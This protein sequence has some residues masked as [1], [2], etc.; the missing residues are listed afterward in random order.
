MPL[1]VLPISFGTVAGGRASV[2]GLLER[3]GGDIAA[4]LERLEGRVEMAVRAR[5]EA[6]NLFA[7]YVAASPRLEAARDRL[8]RAGATPDRD[9][10]LAVGRLFADVL[11]EERAAVRQSFLAATA[12]RTQDVQVRE[13]QREEQ[14]FDLAFLLAADAVGGFEQDV[15]AVAADLADD[16]VIDLA[17]PLP[18]YSFSTLR[19]SF[20]IRDGRP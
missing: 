6:D 14:L 13:P 17:G 9:T 3:H 12:G 10:M 18:P 1:G 2:E 11:E 15:E 8:A 19:L 20:E 4:D 7:R 5:V 16:V